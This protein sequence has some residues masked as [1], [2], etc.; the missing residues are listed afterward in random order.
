MQDSRFNQQISLRD[1]HDGVCGQFDLTSEVII[2]NTLVSY[3][4]VFC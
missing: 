3:E 4:K 1:F 2:G